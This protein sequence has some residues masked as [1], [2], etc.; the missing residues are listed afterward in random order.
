[1][2]NKYNFL[3][4]LLLCGITFNVSGKDLNKGKT[5][6][7]S[8]PGT[9]YQTGFNPILPPWEHIPDGEPRVFGDRVY[10]YG[11]HD[12]AGQNLFCDTIY[13]A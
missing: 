8:L 3:S 9:E 12:N 13:H 1:M 5:H 7:G 2:Y 6:V 11:S 4:L 10:L